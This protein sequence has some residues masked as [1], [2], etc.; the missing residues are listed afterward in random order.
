MCF[1][2]HRVPQMAEANPKRFSSADAR[3]KA[4]E[5][6]GLANRISD[7]SHRAMLRQMAETWDQMATDIA[8]R[9]N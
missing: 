9:E 7:P 1:D 6:R 2:P 8:K 3:E 5:C 4:E